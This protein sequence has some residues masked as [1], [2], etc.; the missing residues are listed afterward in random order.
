MKIVVLLIVMIFISGNSIAQDCKVLKAEL[1]ATYKGECKKGLAHGT[2]TAEGKDSYVGEFKKGLP[3]G[4]GIYIWANGAIYRGYMKKGLRDGIGS[5]VWHTANGDSTLTGAWSNDR[6]D[7]YGN[8]PY[9]VGR[10]ESI[11]RYSIGKGLAIPNKITI[12]IMREGKSF[13]QVS[14]LDVF[15]TSGTD[16]INGTYFEIKDAVF[17]EVLK[18]TFM[19]PNLMNTVEIN[20]EFN[21][22][23]NEAGSWDIIL[24]I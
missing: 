8:S 3:D 13:S 6:Y 22:T 12:R 10:N 18:V 21:L 16:N 20:C 5:Y 7:R 17:P 24:N 2:G 15:R 9:L 14:N 4:K 23:I 1:S 11:I 19:V